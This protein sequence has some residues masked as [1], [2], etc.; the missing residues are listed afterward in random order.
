MDCKCY[1]AAPRKG[2]RAIRV[3]SAL[4]V[5]GLGVVIACSSPA[6]PSLLNAVDAAAIPGETIGARDLASRL[7]RSATLLVAIYVDSDTVDYE[8][9]AA[10]EELEEYRALTRH[11]VEFDPSVLETDA[12][13]LAFWINLYNALVMDSVL[14][15]GVEAS[16]RE[17][18]GFF[19]RYAYAIGKHVYTPND[20]E[21]GI[22][23]G[24]AFDDDD[25]RTQYSL[26]T[27]EPRIHFALNC[28]SAG[29]PPIAAYDAERIEEQLDL[30]AR[31]FVNSPSSVTVDAESGIVYLSQIFG[32]YGEDFGS[33]D[34]AVLAFIAPYLADGPSRNYLQAHLGSVAVSYYEYD[35][36]LNH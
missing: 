9:L 15:S 8:G 11:L 5:A 18:R 21:H 22:L 27:P 25:A 33:G 6:S 34:D 30:A 13:R 19:D 35:W 26:E 32:W 36:A 23:R 17:Q 7:R 12:E 24:V 14:A 10:S 20:I 28:A 3:C 31:A 29:C 1:H 2:K 16:V 4:V